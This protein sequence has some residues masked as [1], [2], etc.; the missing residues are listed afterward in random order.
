MPGALLGG[1]TPTA[2]LRASMARSADG[3]LGAQL[4]WSPWPLG[5]SLATERRRSV[6][7]LTP[8]RSHSRP[9]AYAPSLLLF[10]VT[11]VEDAG[12]HWE[13]TARIEKVQPNASAWSERF[14]IGSFLPQKLDL[15]ARAY[16]DNLSRPIAVSLQ[17]EIRVEHAWLGVGE[18]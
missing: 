7:S 10:S 17:V 9:P 8:P 12:T 4:R 18:G 2:A 1:R 14:W 15:V 5:R 6:R 3:S 11:R 16:A 13:V